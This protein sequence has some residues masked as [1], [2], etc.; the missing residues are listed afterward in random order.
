MRKSIVLKLVVLGVVSVLMLIAL[1]SIGDLARER[2]GRAREVQQDIASKYAGTQRLAG[3][4]F[5]VTFR[6]Y[7]TER[8]YNKEKDTWYDKEMVDLETKWFFPETFNYSGE[9]SVEERYIGIFKAN[10]FQ[11]SGR[12]SGAVVFPAFE[13]LAQRTGSRMELVS[14]NACVLM[15]DLR[16][17][18]S[19]EFRWQGEA[20]EIVRG[21]DLDMIGSGVHAKLPDLGNLFG[22]RFEFEMD[23]DTKGMGSLTFVPIGDENMIRLSSAWPHPSFIGDFLA[24]DRTVSDEGFAAEWNVNGLATSAQQHITRVRKGPVQQLGVSLVDPVNVYSLTDRALKYGFLFIFITF[25]AFFMFEMLAGLRIHPVQYGFVGLAQ[26]IFFL[27]LLS[28]S[29]H[30]GFGGSYLVAAAATIGVIAFYLRHVL[31]SAG[32]AFAFGGLLVLLYGV[33]F[34][35]LQ[36]EDHALVAGSA[37]VFGLMALTMLLTRRVDWYAIGARQDGAVS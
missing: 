22:E 13:T 23:L 4:I 2:K 37:L 25:A 15:S 32:R 12:V 21:S 6:E 18:D 26:S 36:S 29:E 19:P 1:A 16:G 27:L 33:L 35:L 14:A 9:M 3:P 28:L 10:V 5:S 31:R 11:S 8:T 7:W 30:L 24:T 34:A 17:L 20:L